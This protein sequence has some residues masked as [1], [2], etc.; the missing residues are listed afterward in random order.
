LSQNQ[1]GPL[2]NGKTMIVGCDV[3][4][5]SPGSQKGTPSIAGVVA[6]CDNTDTQ[7]PASLRLQK[8]R[9]EMI[10]AMREMMVERLRLWHTRNGSQYPESIIVYRDGVSE[11]Q[12]KHVLERELPEIKAACKS[13][14]PTYKPKISIIVV[15][16]RHHTR[17]YPTDEAGSDGKTGNCRPGT[18]V[19]R[20][21]TAVYDFDFYLQAH[22]GIKGTA[23]PAHYYVIH[24]EHRFDANTLQSMT[25]NLCYLFGRATKSVSICPPAYYADLVCERGRCYIYGLLNAA[26]DAAS[27]ATGSDAEAIENTVKKAN[28]LWGNGVHPSLRGTMFYL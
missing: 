1:L 27:S 19:D 20:G 18:V 12:Y 9:E 22:A 4:H 28:Q 21:V 6:S 16:K 14:G 5:P 2:A 10:L 13:I 3:T 25:H 11:G 23:R 8:S 15:G 24:N 26:D 17:F 7:Y